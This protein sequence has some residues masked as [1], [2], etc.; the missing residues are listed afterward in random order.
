VVIERVKEKES[1]TL[2]GW[3]VCTSTKDVEHVPKVIDVRSPMTLVLQSILLR[4]RGKV[5]DEVLIHLDA[6]HPLLVEIHLEEVALDRL[7]LVAPAQDDL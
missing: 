1:L 7:L 3:D 6:Q 4:E 5:S 2:V